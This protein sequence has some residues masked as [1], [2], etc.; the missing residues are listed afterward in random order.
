MDEKVAGLPEARLD[1]QQQYQANL[2]ALLTART[3]QL[4]K[5][6][7]FIEE[8]VVALKP[9]RPDLARK[10]VEKGFV[11]DEPNR[12]P[13]FGGK[14]E[15]P[16]PEVDPE[17]LKTVWKINRDVQTRHPGQQVA[18]GR[19]V[20]EHVCKPGA[21]I[22]AVGYRAAVLAMLIHIAENPENPIKQLGPW[23]KKDQLEDVVFAAAA[24][25]PMQWMGVGIVRDGPPLDVNEFVQLCGR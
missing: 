6:L 8:L 16:V 15:E 21:D 5:A 2:E 19:G 1:E 24:K 17:D 4:R 9:H 13:R 10:A 11:A 12:P 7:T 18:T 3:E 25:I 20:F 22:Q 23:L 14:P